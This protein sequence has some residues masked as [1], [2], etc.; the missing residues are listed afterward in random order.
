MQLAQMQGNPL[1]VR[2]L[3]NLPSRLVL[4]GFDWL[5]PISTAELLQKLQHLAAVKGGVTAVQNVGFCRV[6][7]ST[8]LGN[9][10]QSTCQRSCKNG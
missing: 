5:R 8:H 2:K 7:G 6:D 9:L 10:R 4:S 3:S 1:R